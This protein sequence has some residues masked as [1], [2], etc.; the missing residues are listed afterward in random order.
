MKSKHSKAINK[1]SSLTWKIESN[2]FEF[3]A[4]KF[5]SPERI[6]LSF[7][8]QI[9][10]HYDVLEAGKGHERQGQRESMELRSHM[11]Y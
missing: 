6:R 3:N 4:Y 1:F 10:M 5:I 2:L 9:L 8:E 11:K 7:G